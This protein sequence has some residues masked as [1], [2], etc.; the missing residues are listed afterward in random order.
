MTY[1]K[2]D[3]THIHG[4]APFWFINGDITRTNIAS[5]LDE[6]ISK[7][8]HEVIVH[9]RYGIAVD[10][11]S[12]D[13]F[14]I[15]RCCLEGAKSRSMRIWIYD[16]LN[17]PSG[18]AGMTVQAEDP[19]FMSKHLSVRAVARGDIDLMFFE[20]GQFLIAGRLQ[21][22]RITRTKVLPDLHALR[23]LDNSWLVFNCHIKRD[24]FYIDTLSKP[25]VDRFKEKT[26]EQYKKRFSDEMGSEI[27]AVFTDEPSIY[28]VSVGYDDWTI[29][30]TEQIF[31][32]F[33]EHY[34]YSAIP[35]IPYLFFPGHGALA[36][37][38]DFWEHV[39][40][41]F[42]TNY[43]ANLAQW[44]SENGLLYTGHCH[45]EEPLRYQ[46]RFQGDMFGA[47]KLMDIPGVDHLGKA[48][49]GNQLISILGHKIASSTAHALGKPRVLSESFGAMGWDT[50]FLDLKKV[51]DWQFA[52]GI[53][54][55]VPHA[56]FHTISGTMKRE[57]PPSLFIQSPQWQD[58]DAF[59]AYID[60]LSDALTGGK[61]ICRILILYPLSGLFAAYQPDSKTQEFECI[62]SFLNLLCIELMRRH[63]DFDLT[64]FP[65]LAAAQTDDGKIA[66]GD[67]RY[68]ILIVPYTPY[69]R[70]KEYEAIGRVAQKA[71][72]YFFCR[73]GDP[74]PANCPSSSGKVQFVQTEDL[75]GFVMR[76]R[77]SLDDGI[78]LS[79]TG[80]EDILLLQ[81]EKD[82]RR[83]AF[84]AN[85]SDHTRRITIRF[86]GQVG[87]TL[88]EPETGAAHAI[89][90]KI[91]RGKTETAVHFAP[92]QSWLLLIGEPTETYETDTEAK[93]DEKELQILS[94]ETG[95]NVAA[96]FDFEY[97][98]DKT[99][100]DV[101][102]DPRVIPVNWEQVQTDVDQFAGTYEATLQI[103]GDPGQIRMVVDREYTDC[104]T[105]L[106]GSEVIFP[107]TQNWLIDPMDLAADVT[108]MIKEGINQVSV[109][110]P[111]KLS[112]PIRFAGN[113]D[114][115]Q[116]DGQVTISPMEERQPFNLEDSMPFY[117]GAVKYHA[118]FTL[119]GDHLHVELD[120]GHIHGSSVVYINNKLAG[121]R[122]WPPYEFD[123]T[124]HVKKGRN[125]LCIEVRNNLSNL[126]LGS[127]KPFGL[128]TPPKLL[129]TD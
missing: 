27:R 97:E 90:A 93:A 82:G 23:A 13:W 81:R 7:G 24:K 76:L 96:I 62:D 10:Y 118:D 87:L 40:N 34:R 26:H 100:F 33:E 4:M 6:M 85:R 98:D 79:G 120:L 121:K 86:T 22:G 31:Q 92:Y 1:K 57:C 41:L 112:E 39:A 83:I 63:L 108:E 127:H 89:Q 37:R 84:V 52:Q 42:N 125:E 56:L 128:K 17:W 129:I 44:C 69:M 55:F 102:K 126:L 113:F 104:R 105:Y 77:H 116:A 94:V 36:F 15:F 103:I 29:P 115:T 21:G 19:S 88:I 45:Y 16:E 14:Q 2:R 61:H 80:R 123:I 78:H 35:N 58:F 50:D 64:D 111:T 43:H 99:E 59:S 53:N 72:T 109:I 74:V 65:T 9:P 70:T 46:I 71:E 5:E 49:L 32:T 119:D 107:P 66:I 75:P 28:W 67:E 47:L 122:L 101:R 95:E 106:N 117:S 91:V 124:K 30:Y 25:A 38:A 114:V 3:K 110:S 18:T 60:R 51:V 48:T 8:I 20:P 11:L 54:L 12:D 73:S 68:D